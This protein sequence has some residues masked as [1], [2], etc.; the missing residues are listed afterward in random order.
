[1][2][3]IKKK[4]AYVDFWSHKYTKS[5]DFLRKIL[6]EE[7]E[8]IDFWWKPRMKIPIDRLN[9]F[10]HIFFFHA[11]FPYQVLK[12]LKNKKIMWAPMYDALN[13]R[14]NF[15]KSIYWK[16]MSNLG[17]KILK[18]SNKIT[19]SIGSEKIDSLRLDY[20]IKPTLN[21]SIN[22][23]KK[24]NIFFWDRGRINFND[25]YNFFNKKEINQ[26]IYFPMPDPGFN[27]INN[28]LLNLK[29]HKIKRIDKKFLSKKEYLKLF[30]MC[31]VFIAPR[32]KEGIGMSI[33]E[34]ISKG[35]FL[36]GYNDSTMNEY[37]SNNKIGFIYDENTNKKINIKNIVNN[38]KYRNIS[39]KLNYDKWTRDKNK[40]I[41]LL[42][43][44][45]KIVK[46]I[47]FSLLFILDDFKC[48]IKKIFN[49]NFYY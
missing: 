13:F 7:F 36:V 6:S 44:E 3:K 49:I 2:K 11:I 21:Q 17:V 38:Y 33:V 32:K 40:I 29:E 9:K 39:A 18:F 24:L 26:I 12:K 42:K 34:A 41:P 37:I 14:N 1:L 48:F 30:K 31:N 45:S 43:A 25:W 35:I 15:F 20:F 8:I 16:Q 23:S 19:E 28:D 4:L 47:H 27:V 5:G 10:E 46:K 22:K